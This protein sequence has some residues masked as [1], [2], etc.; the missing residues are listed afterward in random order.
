[1][2]ENAGAARKMTTAELAAHLGGRL[3]G[4]GEIPITGVNTIQD[5]S[6]EQICFLTDSKHRP[7][8]AV[9]KAGAVLVQ[10]ELDDCRVVQI[11]VPDV[12]KALI[13]TLRL[14][15]PPQR[16]WKGVH[17]TA[18]VEPDAVLEEGV[19]IGPHTY[20]GRQ[21][22]IGAFTVIGPNCSIGE[23]TQIGSHCRLDSNVAVYHDCRIGNYCILQS[24]CTIGAVGFG[25]AFVDGRHQ[26]IPHN[27][28]VIL[29]DEVEIGANSCVDRAKFGNTVVGAGTKIDNLVQVAHNVRIGRACLLA[30]EVGLSGSVVLGDG[31]VLAGQVGVVDHVSIGSGTVVGAAAAVVE[32][33]PAG[34]RLWGSPAQELSAEKRSVIWY[35]RLPALA[36]QLKELKKKVK[37]IEDAKNNPA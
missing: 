25:Y 30:G 28:G 11:V 34:C 23:R 27:G 29:E 5:A 31:V 24:H 8:L 10:A 36:E 14:F 37:Q 2:N 3:V 4:S 20:I 19:G 6:P 33:A 13:E 17:P 35:R 1:M 21:V 15:A 7:L 12:Q 26:L 9:S 22:R 18:V 16:A 32:D